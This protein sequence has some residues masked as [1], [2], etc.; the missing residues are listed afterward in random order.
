M[1]CLDAFRCPSAFQFYFHLIF[2]SAFSAGLRR[3]IVIA[4]VL[5]TDLGF[6]HR[7]G[8]AQMRSV[9]NDV[10]NQYDRENAAND[11]GPWRADGGGDQTEGETSHRSQAAID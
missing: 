5:L 10:R 4:I 6:A 8:L 2:R 11:H 1:P 7:P 3:F 9:Q